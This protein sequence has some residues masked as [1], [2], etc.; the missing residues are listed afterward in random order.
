MIK[1]PI[2]LQDLRR[3]LYIKAKAEPAWRFW[4]LYVHVC[5]QETLREAYLLARANDGAPGIDGV[6][7]EAVE[8][9][10]TEQFLGQLRE[11]LMQRTYRPQAARKV[12]IPK[13][14]GKMRQLS[15]PSIRDRVVQGTLKLILKPIF[16]ADFQPGS[17]GYRPKKSAHSAVRRVQ[18]AILEGKTYVIDFDLRAYF[19][20]ARFLPLVN[21]NG[22]HRPRR[23]RTRRNS[24]PRKPKLSVWP[25]LGGILCGWPLQPMLLIHSRLGREEDSAPLGQGVS[26][27]RF[28]LE[29][30]EQGMAIRH[31]GTLCGVPRFVWVTLGSR[32]S[33]IRLISFAMNC[34]GARSA[35][36][37]HATCDVAGAGNGATA[38]PKRARR[39]KPR[40]QA[41][42]EPAGRR[43]SARPYRR[44]KKMFRAGLYARV[45][46]NDQQ[47]LAM[48][49]RAMREYVARRG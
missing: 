33:M 15:I 34:A 41:K 48:Q 45:S 31:P 28:R 19:D 42:E 39:G 6:T 26:A 9:E 46:T 44:P 36:N 3:R 37:P 49:S 32:P 8:A 27:P 40:I 22:I 23:L 38:N 7:F 20:T 30:V 18:A 12:E 13:A 1:A 11:E 21:A 24:N 43:A 2:S 25:T 47:T 10:G 4:G 16:E 17:F 35:G 29:A 14:N 5:K